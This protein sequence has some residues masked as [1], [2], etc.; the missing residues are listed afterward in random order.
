[1]PAR[2]QPLRFVGNDVY[3]I[4][5]DDLDVQYVVKLAIEKPDAT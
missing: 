3:G 5:R 1:M 4:Q 2:F